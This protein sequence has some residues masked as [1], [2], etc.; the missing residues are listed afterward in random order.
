[1]IDRIQEQSAISFADL[2]HKNADGIAAL[3]AQ[4]ARPDIWAVVELLGGSENSVLRVLRNLLRGRR[5]IK[6]N[7]NRRWREIQMSCQKFQTYR[8]A[9]MIVAGLSLAGHFALFG[10]SLFTAAAF[11]LRCHS[12]WPVGG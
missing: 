8:R 9:L 12:T 2:R 11:V 4:G 10:L 5:V 3:I 6:D 7:R 1:M